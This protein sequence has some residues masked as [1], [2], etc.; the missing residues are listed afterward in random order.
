MTTQQIETQTRAKAIAFAKWMNEPI[1]RAAGSLSFTRRCVAQAPDYD[2]YILIN[3]HGD[4]LLP[5][6]TYPTLDGL[7][8]IFDSLYEPK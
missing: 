8:N 1:H 4:S 5:E 2:T 6:G 3:K 7:Y